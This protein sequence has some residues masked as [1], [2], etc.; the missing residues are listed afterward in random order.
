M[1]FNIIADKLIRYQTH[2]KLQ[3]QVKRMMILTPQLRM[4]H[5]LLLRLLLIFIFFSLAKNVDEFFLCASVIRS[6]ILR[7]RNIC[8]GFSSRLEERAEKR[9]EVV[10]VNLHSTDIIIIANF[11]Y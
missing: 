9:K 11:R 7:Q 1:F 4:I 5:I 8:S 2:Q 3:N 10:S 6:A